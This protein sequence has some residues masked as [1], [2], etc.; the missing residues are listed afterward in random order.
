MAVTDSIRRTSS[1]G[2]YVN[3]DH[4]DTGKDLNV[5]IGHDVWVGVRCIIMAGVKIA[6]G[7]VIGA[8]SLVNSDVP[9]YAI[10]VGSPARVIKHRHQPEAAAALLKSEWWR[11]D[12][13]EIWR[14]VSSIADPYDM[15]E[16]AAALS[17]P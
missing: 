2:G 8:G 9:P 12:P 11:L 17:S 6:T 1:G 4:G 16:T 5:E 7:A 14:R 3:F 13:D 15:I 10:A